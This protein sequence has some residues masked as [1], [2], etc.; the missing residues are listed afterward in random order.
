[1]S[2]VSEHSDTRKKEQKGEAR[3]SYDNMLIV[4]TESGRARRENIWP[5]VIALG[6]FAVISPSGPPTQ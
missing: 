6:P 3:R 4:M 5:S 1:M 2:D